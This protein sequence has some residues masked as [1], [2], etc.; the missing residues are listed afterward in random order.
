M[1]DERKRAGTG[2]W[3]TVALAAVLVYPVSFGPACWIPCRTRTGARILPMVYRPIIW[4]WDRL[5]RSLSST[6]YGYSRMG[7]TGDWW[8]RGSGE[9]AEWSESLC[10]TPAT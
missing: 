5:P 10:F 1:S 9:D 4:A 8:W 7:A 2:F 6:L 3:L